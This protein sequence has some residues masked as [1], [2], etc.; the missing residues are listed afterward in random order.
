MSLPPPGRLSRRGRWIVVALVL[1]PVDAD[2]ASP[3]TD[4]VAGDE[5]DFSSASRDQIDE[6]TG[7]IGCDL[8]ADG[9]HGCGVLSYIN[10]E[11]YGGN[12]IGDALWWID[13]PASGEPD[14]FARGDAPAFGGLR[15]AAETVEYGAVVYYGDFVCASEEDGLT[16]WNA[17]TG[18]GAFMHRD[19]Y[20]AF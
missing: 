19:G 14:I 3:F 11:P 13:F 2:G 16:C 1:E 12:E 15:F 5:V 9:S 17:E 4:S 10:D 18:H 7:N 6:A 8:Y 20:E